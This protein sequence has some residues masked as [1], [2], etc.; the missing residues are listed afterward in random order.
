MSSSQWCTIESDPGVFTA[1]VE[2][3]GVKG[4]EFTECYSLDDETLTSLSEEGV[5]GLI[6]L[7]K[8]GGEETPEAGGTENTGHAEY[9]T[10]LSGDDVPPGLFFARQVTGNAC[11]T[12][13]IL[14]ILLNA[15]PAEDDG[16]STVSSS[17]AVGDLRLGR[18]LAELREFT[19]HFDAGLRGETI[20]AS[21]DI[22]TAHNSFARQE[23]LV[24]DDGPKS[25]EGEQEDVFHFV[26][27]V[28]YPPPRSASVA[29]GGGEVEVLATEC[30]ELDGLQP[31]PVRVTC[32]GGGDEGSPALPSW[33]RT[34]RS[35]IQTRIAK[36]PPGEV[37]FNL[38]AVVS[39]RRTAL[40]QQL[41]ETMVASA[42]ANGEEKDNLVAAANELKVRLM[43][44][45]NKRAQWRKEN[46]RRRHN[47]LPFCFELLKG[48][49]ASGKMDEFVKAANEKAE[50]RKLASQGATTKA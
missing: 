42:R 21:S 24:G 20:G 8:H 29:E 49:A 38:M 35:A 44:E 14:S 43:E 10:L 46:E 5:Y 50:A 31:G 18:T 7:F 30:Y 48:M 23:A 11:A 1:L 16:T 4:V 41:R 17:L 15:A 27:Y 25:N 26:A 32:K 37:K 34:A 22:R 3:F 28:P 45:G 40:Q 19:R 12:Q 6:F 33:L 9:G 13:A 39:D 36:Y 47:Y 2:A